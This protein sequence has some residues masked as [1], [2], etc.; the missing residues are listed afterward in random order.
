[1]PPFKTGVPKFSLPKASAWLPAIAAFLCL[2][3]FAMA[4]MLLVAVGSDPKS[5]PSPV[6]T[7][8]SG[9][10]FQGL[11]RLL[12]AQGHVTATNRFED[13]GGQKDD[14]T[15]GKDQV[16][17]GD[18][19]VITFDAYNPYADMLR[20]M[21]QSSS[22]SSSSGEGVSSSSA[23]ASS[24]SASES[25]ASEEAAPAEDNGSVPDKRRADHILYKPLGRAVI[26]V[27]PKWR[28]APAQKNPRWGAD[29]G[30]VPASG[31]AE[32]LTFLSPMDETGGKDKKDKA[33]GDGA[34]LEAQYKAAETALDNHAPDAVAKLR[35]VAEAGYPQAQYRLGDLY[36]GAGKYLP[37]DPAQER[38][39]MQ[40]A[41]DNGVTDAMYE[42]GNDF[43]NGYGGPQDR[44]LAAQ[45]YRAAAERGVVDC[46]FNLAFMYENG[47]GVP[48]D[49]AE[50]YKWYRIA[51][52]SGDTE[53]GGDA[54]AI[55][56]K[57][58][59]ADR[60]RAEREA[61]DF[62]PVGQAVSQATY[63]TDDKQITY[64]PTTGGRAG[65][66]RRAAES[67]AH[68]RPAIDPRPEPGARAAWPE[69]RTSHLAPHRHRRAAAT[70]SARLCRVR[71]GPAQQPDPGRPAKGGQ[72]AGDHR[73]DVARR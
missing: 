50:A 7:S 58:N 63:D 64:D 62:V 36:S 12:T 73:Q 8:V 37:E 54:K 3:L 69:R 19:E 28:T 21:Q 32:R 24:S 26:I 17:R 35:V 6:V 68:L 51:A 22:A 23:A 66:I 9:Q 46:Q 67:W 72:R 44:P 10:G 45:W 33:F 5:G 20:Q 43:Y 40:K 29:A 49:L 18:I 31:I 41:A 39:W 16:T 25:A 42:L 1:M 60:D 13:G 47:N 11:R 56:D 71:S 34:S 27:L 48:K 53:A 59:P 70:E 30:L 2:S 65:G 38:L 55:G 57:L 4:A 61:V 14:K 15:S 52:N